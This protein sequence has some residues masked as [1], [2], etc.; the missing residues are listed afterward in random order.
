LQPGGVPAV[1]LSGAQ[2]VQGMEYRKWILIAGAAALTALVTVQVPVAAAAKYPDTVVEAALASVAFRAAPPTGDALAALPFVVGDLA[3]F[4]V[5]RVLTGNVLGLTEGPLDADADST[6]PLIVIAWVRQPGVP[7]GLQDNYAR[8]SLAVARLR[9]PKVSTGAMLRGAGGNWL[10]LEATGPDVG[11]GREM[12]AYQALHFARD[13]V[14]QVFGL[15]RAEG[16]AA[17]APRFRQ[18]AASVR[19]R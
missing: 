3:G 12:Y 9:S 7:P 1:L 18:V 2:T 6:Q 5:S 14:M 10:V 11:S 4:R 15:A 16:W 13:S 19:V 8:R 17:L